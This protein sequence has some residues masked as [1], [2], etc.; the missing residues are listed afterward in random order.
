[1]TTYEAT[2]EFPFEKM[3]LGQPQAMQGGGSYFTKL[4]VDNL[5]ILLQM[6]KCN[7]KNGIIKTKRVTYCDLMY[8]KNNYE[9]LLSE[10]VEKLEETCQNL[11]DNKKHLWFSNELSRDDLETM[12]SSLVRLYRSGSKALMRTYI[13]TSRRNGNLKCHIYDENER[14]LDSDK[15]TDKSVVIP[16][17]QI[18][19]IKFTSRS[20]DVELKLV[21]LMVLEETEEIIFNKNCMIKRR[22]PVPEKVKLENTLENDKEESNASESMSDENISQ[23]NK[24]EINT[25]AI[26]S[27]QNISEKIELKETE[28]NNHI[29]L[30]NIENELDNADKT[31]SASLGNNEIEEVTLS[32]DNLDNA[33]VDID[34][35]NSSEEKSINDD[36]SSIT[37]ELSEPELKE[38][39]IEVQEELSPKPGIEEV[40]LN[41]KDNDEIMTLKKPNE[42]YYEIYRAAREKAK[43]MR[44]VALEAY[45]EAKQIKTKY[46]LDDLD[47]SDEDLD[48]GEDEISAVGSS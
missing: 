37:T 27:T 47:E 11:I 32:L 20:F 48:F 44:K 23:E 5:P 19:G 45:L 33:E 8:G 41:V 30:E 34:S 12:M 25:S 9:K 40:E 29:T 39:T 15:V 4:T 6:P 3:V 35:E 14:I 22:S 1:M 38:I 7:M 10:W 17:I 18:E 28:N 46:M 24:I 21:Q 13:D 42:V 16:L 43:H 31:S 26:D 2:L 36:V